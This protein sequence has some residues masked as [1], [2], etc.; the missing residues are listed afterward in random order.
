[1]TESA[2]EILALRSWIGNFTRMNKRSRR[3]TILY[4]MAYIM[5]FL[6]GLWGYAIE[7]GE[8]S[9]KV[10]YSSLR[11]YGINLDLWP[12]EHNLVLWLAA[13]LAIL[14]TAAIIIKLVNR[15]QTLF[16]NLWCTIIPSRSIQ[17]LG[18]ETYVRL[19]REHGS[20]G[21]KG[22]S[23][24]VT[25]E[26]RL[27]FR[28]S[29][30]VIL[31]K[32][33]AETLRIYNRINS[34]LRP[35]AE[36]YLHMEQTS[37]RYRVGKRI[38]HVFS[39]SDLIAKLFWRKIWREH[40]LLAPQTIVLIGFGSLG[41]ALLRHAL[42]NNVAASADGQLITHRYVIAGPSG[43]FLKL[44]RELRHFTSVGEEQPD[45]DTLIFLESPWEDYELLR[46]ASMII[47]C[48][49]SQETNADHLLKLLDHVP[50]IRPEHTRLYVHM[51]NDPVPQYLSD[52]MSIE[53]FPSMETLFSQ[54]VILHSE[55]QTLARNIHQRYQEENPRS[56]GWDE[57]D[58]FTIR[59]NEAQAEHLEVKLAMLGLARPGTDSRSGWTKEEFSQKVEQFGRET[60]AKL[61]HIRWCRFHWLHNW[62]YDSLPGEDR[63]K[64]AQRRLHRH[65]VP[66]EQLEEEV[67]DYDRHSV[68]SI[69]QIVNS[70]PSSTKRRIGS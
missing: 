13:F 69:C 2:G 3:K 8:W 28:A 65:L 40:R 35:D 52:K 44:H 30:T 22:S 47:F 18:D 26:D 24:I 31:G 36:V 63:H 57:L 38:I 5:P 62:R 1:V 66:Y 43:E 56:P 33:R 34:R 46:S 4:V 50:G 64:D 61:E 39:L 27:A 70:I 55:L 17:V 59:S 25:N 42:Q 23:R 45:K 11:L 6:L 54:Q 9:L 15:L 10:V 67:K 53:I 68:D 16:S 49:D 7:F 12:G 41:Q 21:E 58:Y 60:L 37:E 51:E 32:N 19:F 48:D 20:R 14:V 29:K